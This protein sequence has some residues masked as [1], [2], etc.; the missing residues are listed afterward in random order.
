MPMN[1]SHDTCHRWL[2]GLLLLPFL[3]VSQTQ[4]VLKT[5]RIGGV[6][7]GFF[8]VEVQDTRKVTANVG[9]VFDAKNQRTVALLENSA[10]RTLQGFFN[11]NF[12]P[13]NTDSLT[14]IALVIKELKFSERLTSPTKIA[15]ELTTHFS[16]EA[17]QNGRQVPLTGGSST[18]TY[19]RDPRQNEMLE[20]MLRQAL[21]NQIR[22]FG[23]WYAQNSNT[24][25]KLTRRVEVIFDEARQL[26]A[27]TII[28]YASTR[29]LTW[30]DFRGRPSLVSRWAA[31]VF[32]SFGFEARSTIKNRVV[33]LHVRTNVWLDKTIS[34]GRANAK[35]DYVLAHEQLHFDITQLTALRFKKKIKNLIFSTEDYSSEIQYQYLEFFRDL[36][37]LQQQY[38]DETNHGLNQAKQYFW[39]AKIKQELKNFEGE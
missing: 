15:G 7:K 20:Q 24:F 23:K 8:V 36:G 18:S 25:D 35:N 9:N 3:G 16:F 28:D 19:T 21:G 14:A 37:Q 12:N 39:A 17:Y 10:V 29:P 32:T 27:D 33:Q 5:E 22:N 11:R 30:A 38:D 1:L 2:L 4:I 6:A 34:W 13:D 26:D 31:Q